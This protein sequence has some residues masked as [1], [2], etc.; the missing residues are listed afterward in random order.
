MKRFS[1]KEI[2]FIKDNI[3]KISYKDIGIELNRSTDVIKQKVRNLKIIIFGQGKN[4]FS[5]KKRFY[6]VNDDYFSEPNLNNCYWAG[7]IAAD[8][9]ILKPS[10]NSV[11][12]SI[13]LSKKDILHLECLKKEI[14]SDKVIYNCISNGFP[15]ISITIASKKIVENLNNHYKNIDGY[16]MNR[17]WNNPKVDEVLNNTIK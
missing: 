15:C 17:K 8:G 4:P 9:Y 6:N 3:N 13:M 11:S 16:K 1:E 10:D 5:R 7:F 2:N 12:L 14:E